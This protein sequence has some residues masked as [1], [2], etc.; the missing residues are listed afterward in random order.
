MNKMT[1]ESW[2]QSYAVDF[3]F[4]NEALI[5]TTCLMLFGLLFF[6]SGTDQDG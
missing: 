6:E 1:L 3:D 4:L 5:E 2:A